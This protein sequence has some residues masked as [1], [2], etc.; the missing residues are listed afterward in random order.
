MGGNRGVKGLLDIW[1]EMNRS[2]RMQLKAFICL[3]G[4]F[5]LL[6]LI[7]VGLLCA[8]GGGEE[9]EPQPSESEE[10]EEH[11]PVV[12]QL[13]N[14]WIME[15]DGEGLLCYVD[16]EERL[17]RIAA[18]VS[19]ETES[20]QADGPESTKEQSGNPYGD[21]SGQQSFIQDEVGPG[22]Q[23]SISDTDWGTD[24]WLL[25]LR[26]QVADLELT[27]G[28]VTGVSAKSQKI[29]GKVLAA[30]QEGVWLEGQGRL[31]FTGDV[32]GYRLY[33]ELTGA[34]Y[35]DLRIGYD[36]AD[37]CLEE[38]RICAILL[39]REEAME[40]IRV[41]LKNSD[42]QGI[43]HD[44]VE[45]TCDTD[46]TV[47]VLSAVDAQETIVGYSAGESLEFSFP[48]TDWTAVPGL[49][50]DI[51]TGEGPGLPAQRGS[52]WW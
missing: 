14:V 36:S 40:T 26:E 45:L 28:L 4:I 29:S 2:E 27:D 32:Q 39:A 11:I 43:Y 12:E 8:R 47:Q 7:V 50:G 52:G 18:S 5:L 13:H 16:G 30:D 37:F 51:G 21:S 48:N 20:H 22:W 34:T 15:A 25:A 9:E 3:L 1:K 38:G 19:R 23:S 35:R 10:T 6:L 24:A 33:R 46:Y 31:E 42:Y 44:R 17:L 41:L 49:S